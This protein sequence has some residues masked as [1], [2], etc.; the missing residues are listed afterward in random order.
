MPPQQP[1]SMSPPPQP[2]RE[3]GDKKKRKEWVCKCKTSNW[4]SSSSCRDCGK[5]RPSTGSSKRQDRSRERRPAKTSERAPSVGRARQEDSKCAVSGKDSDDMDTEFMDCEEN[6]WAGMT[7]SAMKAEVVRLQGVIQTL[8]TVQCC[9]LWSGRQQDPRMVLLGVWQEQ[10]VD[11]QI[12]RSCKERRPRCFV[13]S[14]GMTT[15]PQW[16]SWAA[17]Q[18]TIPGS[19]TVLQSQGQCHGS[20]G[21]GT[22]TAAMGQATKL[23]AIVELGTSPSTFRLQPRCH[24][25]GARM[26]KAMPPAQT[27]WH[28]Q[29]TKRL[30]ASGEHSI[31]VPAA[32]RRPVRNAELQMGMETTIP[33]PPPVIRDQVAFPNLHCHSKTDPVGHGTES[34]LVV[35]NCNKGAL[36][37]TGESR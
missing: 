7:T 16:E 24:G 34:Q 32:S 10:L 2:V 20:T 36:D 14:Q 29:Q 27:K 23:W 8:N 17:V 26:V 11:I 28:Q 3:T 37:A 21:N 18:Q 19:I 22:A 12:C 33:L 13:L 9:A 30:G 35:V 5:E 25:S 1:S 4:E 6:S 31:I 15:W